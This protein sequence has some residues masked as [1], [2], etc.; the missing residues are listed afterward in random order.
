MEMVLG[1]MAAINLFFKYF[2]KR[3]GLL[4]HIFETND[5]NG[6]KK[7][8]DSFMQHKVVWEGP[9]IPTFS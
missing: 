6:K 9:W 7:S 8:F 4:K 1:K 5:S 2:P 3:G